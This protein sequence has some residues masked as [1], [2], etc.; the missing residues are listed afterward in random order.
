[1]KRTF[2]DWL[3][4]QLNARGWSQNEL[5]RRAGVTSAAV[6]YV[7]TELRAPGPEFCRGVARA[8]GIPE[9]IVFVEA[10]LMRPARKGNEIT[11]QELWW[12]LQNLPIED[13]EAILE[14]ARRRLEKQSRNAKLQDEQATTQ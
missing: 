13:Q 1:M 11:L 2:A 14:E 8:L 5:A 9:I 7:M 4:E 3:R 6:S 12:L 10:G